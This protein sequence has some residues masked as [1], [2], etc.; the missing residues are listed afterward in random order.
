MV[1]VDSL[2]GLVIEDADL[3]NLCCDAGELTI[4]LLCRF[5]LDDDLRLSEAINTKHPGMMK[6]AFPAS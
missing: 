3:L 4:V 5:I 6:L 2:Y 1:A